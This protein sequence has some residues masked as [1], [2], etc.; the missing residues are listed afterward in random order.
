M[1]SYIH[2]YTCI[3]FADDIHDE[4]ISAEEVVAS[5]RMTQEDWNVCEHYAKELFELSQ[6]IAL[7]KVQHH[8]N[9]IISC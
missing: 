9:L 6:S 7:T 3:I 4:L 2:I 8:G 5:G 1:Y